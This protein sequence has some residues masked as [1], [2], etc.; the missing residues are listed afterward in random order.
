MPDGHHRPGAFYKTLERSVGDCPGQ[1]L[2]GNLFLKLPQRAA[3]HVRQVKIF[4]KFDDVTNRIV[5]LNQIV[6]RLTFVDCERR[7]RSSS[8][9]AV[10]KIEIE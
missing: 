9:K 8:M 6:F 5:P 1:L 3:V 7:E 10:A 4:G 2:C